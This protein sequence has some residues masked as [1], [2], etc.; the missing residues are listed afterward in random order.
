VLVQPVLIWIRSLLWMNVEMEIVSESIFPPV[1]WL[2]YCINI[3]I[4]LARSINIFSLPRTSFHIP[5]IFVF[6]LARF[7]VVGFLHIEQWMIVDIWLIF[8][9]SSRKCGMLGSVKL[10]VSFESTRLM[11]PK[12]PRLSNSKN[13]QQCSAKKRGS[14]V[15]YYY[16][17]FGFSCLWSFRCFRSFW[18]L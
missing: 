5:F 6:Q 3:S 10:S 14:F 9:V 17:P 2:Y 4:W 15:D 11:I 8:R 7:S 18:P 16:S 12:E 13:G 1:I